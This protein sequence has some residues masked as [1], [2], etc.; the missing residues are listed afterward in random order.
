MTSSRILILGSRGTVGSAIAAAAGDRAAQAARMPVSKGTFAFDALTDDAT[1]LL[2]AMTV[3]PKAVIIAFGISGVHTCASDPVASSRL[4]VDRVLAVA[5]SA[6]KY[7]A[8]P[9]LFSTDCVFDGSSVLWL[10][11]D[12]TRP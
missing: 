1:R 8:L 4:N 5:T 3:P 10:E 6:A 7:G 11:H 9:V 2:E 12:E